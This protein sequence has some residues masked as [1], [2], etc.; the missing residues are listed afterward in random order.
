LRAVR[1]VD[2]SYKSNRVMCVGGW[3][4]L[5][6]TWKE[7]ESRWTARVEHEQRMSVRK[8]FPPISRYHATYCA[9]LKREFDRS[10]GWDEERQ[11]RFVKQLIDI[12]GQIRL[13]GIAVG[14]SLADT[15]GAFAS[16]QEAEK[17]AYRICMMWCIGLIGELLD[18]NWKDESSHLPRA[19]RAI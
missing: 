5:K 3:L 1:P 14:C 19:Q 8:G 6:E 17:W 11:I 15:V 16:H 9:S 7:I 2:E 12:V 18:E 4:C 10:K 13:I